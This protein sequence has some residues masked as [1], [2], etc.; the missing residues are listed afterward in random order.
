MIGQEKRLNMHSPQR[1]NQFFIPD[2][3]A[4]DTAN[5]NTARLYVLTFFFIFFVP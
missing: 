5:I 3:A 1:M 4:Y 2:R